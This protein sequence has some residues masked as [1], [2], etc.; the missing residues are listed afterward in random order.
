ML[1]VT[2]KEAQIVTLM[3][4]CPVMLWSVGS[5]RRLARKEPWRQDVDVEWVAVVVGAAGV[6]GVS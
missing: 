5:D 6:A 1:L 2:L 3:T 4:F